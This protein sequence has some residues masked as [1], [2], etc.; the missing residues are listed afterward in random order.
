MQN[1]LTL[2]QA[3]GF[4]NWH[5]M[6]R[7]PRYP[8]SV[9]P[10]HVGKLIALDLR[11]MDSGALRDV[12]SQTFTSVCGQVLPLIALDNV[13]ERPPRMEEILLPDSFTGYA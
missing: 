7:S 4:V 5:H 13:S 11:K 1:V 12:F 2:V 9:G 10:Y 8:L 3:K 6:P